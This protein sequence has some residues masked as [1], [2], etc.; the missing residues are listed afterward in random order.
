MASENDALSRDCAPAGGD[1]AGTS[2]VPSGSP[3]KLPEVRPRHGSPLLLNDLRVRPVSNVRRIPDFPD[4]IRRH[5]EPNSHAVNR[6]ADW[7]SAVVLTAQF[8]N[9]PIDQAVPMVVRFGPPP[10]CALRGFFALQE[11]QQPGEV[12]RSSLR[13][14]SRF[15]IRRTASRIPSNQSLSRQANSTKIV[16][17]SSSGS[18]LSGI[19]SGDT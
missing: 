13:S 15:S 8:P 12:V 5:A 11:V 14:G 4:G 17:Q 1:V 7:H 9:A 19:A 2:Q 3:W 6:L 18:K 16:G 10:A